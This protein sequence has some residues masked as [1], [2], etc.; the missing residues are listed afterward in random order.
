MLPGDLQGP[1]QG[2]HRVALR[3]GQPGG[4]EQLVGDVLVAGDVHP[5]RGGV[6]G[7]RGADPPCVA[8]LPELDQRRAVEPHPGD[9]A[10][11]R[12]VDQGLCRGAEGSA[13]GAKQELLE[14]DLE[15]E[16]GVVGHQVVDHAHGQPARGQADRLVLVV[17]DDVVAPG[18]AGAAGLSASRVVPDL[19]LQ[20]Q[21][22]VLGDV[23][24]PGA[25]AQPLG[26]PA[27]PA[28]RAGVLPDSGQPVEQPVGEAGQQVGGVLLE[29]PE[30]DDEVDR[31]GVGP[32]VRPAVD[33]GLEDPEVRGRGTCRG[34]GRRG[35][36]GHGDS[37]CSWARRRRRAA[38]RAT[39]ASSTPSAA[40]RLEMVA[41]SCVGSGRSP[42]STA[43][44]SR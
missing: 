8:A 6:G 14:S 32:H 25:F 39:T 35:A 24:H 4:A 27:L 12:L 2:A 5:E 38:L 37:L 7:H 20:L 34:A 36:V 41:R 42:G 28:T 43:L 16:L 18:I 11:D 15:V 30:V 1:A 29:R 44:W 40:T 19:V 9:V 26:E 31:R 21:G 3:H 13:L 23:P 17:E 33:A 10:G 22:E